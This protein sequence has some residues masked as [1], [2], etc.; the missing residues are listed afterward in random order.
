MLAGQDTFRYVVCCVFNVYRLNVLCSRFPLMSDCYVCYHMAQSSACWWQLSCSKRYCV[1]LSDEN[2]TYYVFSLRKAKADDD[3]AKMEPD[4]DDVK[5][6]EDSDEAM[7]TMKAEEADVRDVKYHFENLTW[8]K[9]NKIMFKSVPVLFDRFV[10]IDLVMFINFDYSTCLVPTCLV[11]KPAKERI[12]TCRSGAE[13]AG[14]N[15]C[16]WSRAV[17]LFQLGWT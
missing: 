11:L 2:V 3:D 1:G 6:D 15:L 10:K 8:R 4:D 7:D 12:C 14:S 9:E 5:K 17:S 16:L 13:S